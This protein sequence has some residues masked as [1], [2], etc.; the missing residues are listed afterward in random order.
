M[1]IHIKTKY[2]QIPL[3]DLIVKKLEKNKLNRDINVFSVTND[4]GFK[5]SL[6]TFKKQVFSKDISTYKLVKRGDFAYNP[7][8][9]NVGSID[10]FKEDQG[11]VSPLYEVFHTKE[12]LDNRYL[13][14]FLKSDLGKFY[15]NNVTRGAVR[16]TLS[17]KRLG[18]IKI[19]LPSLSQ[20]RKIV[21]ILN[22]S[23]DIKKKREENI[24]KVE[25]LIRS[26]FNE[27]F[28][29]PSNNKRNLPVGTIRNLVAEVKY[30]TSSKA[31]ESGKY[32]YLR[33]N[34]ITYEGYMDYTDL[35]YI[36]LTGEETLKYTVK[37]GDLIFNRTNSMELVGKTGVFEEDESMALAGYNIRVRTNKKGNTY[38]R[39][40][41]NN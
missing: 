15:I 17:L 31:S 28:G 12:N 33:M 37:N 18:R 29:T 3:E 25:K 39:V 38:Y 1:K 34:N 2:S 41:S 30:G 22:H 23:D 19:P 40:I 32:P 11:L 10:Y 7:S 20:Q 26:I 35:K 16:N 36:D 6:E 24:L 8:R 14:Y 5:L 4:Q 13:K 21:E 9:I 27:M